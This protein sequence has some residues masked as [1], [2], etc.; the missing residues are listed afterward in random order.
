MEDTLTFEKAIIEVNEIFKYLDANI[1]NKIPTKLIEE[2]KKIKN[3]TY[4]FQYNTSKTLIEQN[5]SE[6]TKDLLSAIY[7]RYCADNKTT[8]ELIEICRENDL[9]AEKKYN[10]DN[11]F[12]KEQKKENE[13]LPAEVNLKKSFFTKIIN[14]IKSF[15]KRK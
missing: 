7:L 1:L 6:E 11:L 10:V 15:F 3:D 9:L 5:I 12:K 13:N 4:S 8:K 14:K 2:F